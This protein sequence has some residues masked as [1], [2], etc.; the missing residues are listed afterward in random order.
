MAVQREKDHVRPTR[1]IGLYHNASLCTNA[2]KVPSH[3]HPDGIGVTVRSLATYLAITYLVTSKADTVCFLYCSTSFSQ[4]PDVPCAT[5][6]RRHRAR[7][8][9][10]RRPGRAHTDTDIS[11]DMHV[12]RFCHT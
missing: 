5:E 8:G 7:F 6:F 12:C 4:C 2:E 3:V 9:R 10:T 1:S 11:T